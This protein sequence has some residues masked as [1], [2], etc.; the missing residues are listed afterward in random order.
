VNDTPAKTNPWAWYKLALANP[1]E[2]GKTPA[3]LVHENDPQ[4]GYY[5]MK[6][7]KGEIGWIPISIYAAPDGALVAAVG[8]WADNV[9]KP[10][11]E[12]WT[13]CCRHPVAYATWRAVA[14][15]GQDWPDSIASLIKGEPSAPKPKVSE[16]ED[17][18]DSN[19]DSSTPTVG[20]NSGAAPADIY[21]ELCDKLEEM[22]GKALAEAEKVGKITGANWTPD[23]AVKKD[24]LANWSA[25]IANV[26]KAV[27]DAFTIEKAPHLAAGRVV[28]EKWRCLKA[29]GPDTVKRLKA[30]VGELIA[31]ETAFKIEEARKAAEA[32][33]LASPELD[34]TPIDVEPIKVSAG[35][36]GRK[37]S[38]VTRNIAVIDDPVA[39]VTF[40]YA[41][42]DGAPNEIKVALQTIAQRLVTGGTAALMQIPGVSSKQEQVAR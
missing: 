41:M 12:V 11:E 20:D 29:K 32:A 4:I 7:G 5:R 31:A 39:F 9:R 36:S 25:E 40:L 8:L 23:A 17:E 34:E 19:G 26:S 30:K 14:A 37:V 27:D 18:D 10:A 35:T 16:P 15:E 2:I 22:A 13:W 1:K 38:M 42:K 6:R 21:A 3:L 33:R 28:D 24:R